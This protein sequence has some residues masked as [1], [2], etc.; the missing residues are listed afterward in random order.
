ML[1]G[2]SPPR[3]AGKPKLCDGTPF[4]YKPG[5]VL[6]VQIKQELYRMECSGGGLRVV[7]WGVDLGFGFEFR[8]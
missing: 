7:V 3:T 8:R 6:E 5:F 2:L 4:P 1:Q